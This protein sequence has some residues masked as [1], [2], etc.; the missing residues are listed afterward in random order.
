MS[1]PRAENRLSEFERV[2]LSQAIRATVSHEGNYTSV[3]A[4]AKVAQPVVSLALHQRLVVRT[5]AVKRLFEYFGI[6]AEPRNGVTGAAAENSDERSLRALRL[7]GML[8]GLSDGTKEADERLATILA[9]LRGF[10]PGH[11]R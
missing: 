8:E 1:R 9:A 11:A 3:V 6:S 7:A 5:P 10:I 4:G 2:A